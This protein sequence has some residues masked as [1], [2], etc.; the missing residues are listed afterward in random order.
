MDNNEL[1]CEIVNLAE[2]VRAIVL[3]DISMKVDS[4]DA[5]RLLFKK[6]ISDIKKLHNS[7]YKYCN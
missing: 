6:N 7:I 2:S 3:F 1:N 4:S 5:A